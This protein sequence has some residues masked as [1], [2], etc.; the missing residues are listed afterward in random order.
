V[1]ERVHPEPVYIGVA[2]VC[3]LLT[4]SR[5]QFLRLRASG[6]FPRARCFGGPSALRW[7]RSEVLAWADSQEAATFATRGGDRSSREDEAA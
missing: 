2:D 3:A 5:R 4:L 6:T 1:S 7:R